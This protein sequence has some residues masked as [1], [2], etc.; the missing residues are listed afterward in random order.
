MKIKYIALLTLTAVALSGCSAIQAV[1]N[2]ADSALGAVNN[3]L[4]RLNV[5]LGGESQSKS[6]SRNS[7]ESETERLWKERHRLSQERLNIQ[8]FRQN[9]TQ[10]IDLFE[11]WLLY[12]IND[13]TYT[14]IANELN[15]Y[16]Q[17]IA[18]QQRGKSTYRPPEYYDV[19][20][21]YTDAY[22]NG[23]HAYRNCHEAVTLRYSAAERREI[24]TDTIARYNQD[25]ADIQ[26][27]RA[28]FIS[29]INQKFGSVQN[30]KTRLEQNRVR[31]R[32]LNRRM[33]THCT[34][35]MRGKTSVDVPMRRR[36]F[37]RPD[38]TEFFGNTYTV[39][40]NDLFCGRNLIAKSI[41]LSN[42]PS[43]SSY[44]SSAWT[45]SRDQLGI[46][47]AVPFPARLSINRDQSF[48]L[49]SDTYEELEF[50]W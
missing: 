1:A 32:E 5:A 24:Y 26:Q 12:S 23:G 37:K 49:F 41:D 10:L 13:N 27:Q 8:Y 44:Y 38:G 9:Q 30:L 18:A 33:N 29:F 15:E 6:R 14:S 7:G 28:D 19:C 42:L 43:L 17:A 31:L 16:N 35:L 46:Q 3:G 34:A 50:S 36:R 47:P 25:I 11:Q 20:T 39:R 21:H 4:D 2:A 48:W 40:S 45:N 22:I